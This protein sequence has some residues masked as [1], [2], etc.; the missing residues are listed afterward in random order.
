[1]SFKAAKPRPGQ[2]PAE[3]RGCH[4]LP[5]PQ[6]GEYLM[7]SRIILIAGLLL[8]LLIGG[9]AA[10]AQRNRIVFI[11]DLHM[12]V[13]ASYSWLVKLTADLAEFLK[14]LSSRDDVAELVI[15]GD[16]LDDWVCPA[17]EEPNSFGDILYDPINHD[18]RENLRALCENK[19]IEVTYMVGNHDMLSFEKENKREIQ[20]PFP[21]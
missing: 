14:S 3:K 15:L 13:D 11:S 8:S 20:Y 18:I 21:A 19:D 4:G 12:N 17:G 10:A 1:V 2:R 6:E 5:S 7:L 16:M 9:S